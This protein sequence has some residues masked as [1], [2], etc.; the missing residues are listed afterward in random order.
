M[1]LYTFLQAYF[2]VLPYFKS[3]FKSFRLILCHVCSNLCLFLFGF[4]LIILIVFNLV[5]DSSL[6]KKVEWKFHRNLEIVTSVSCQHNTCRHQIIIRFD[7]PRQRKIKKV[8]RCE[9]RAYWASKNNSRNRRVRRSRSSST[10]NGWV[11][12]LL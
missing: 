8:K 9:K 11:T 6:S 5:V 4:L 12:T 7:E 2:Q 10:Q 1:R 3:T